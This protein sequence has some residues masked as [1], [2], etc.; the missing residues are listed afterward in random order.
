[1]T[2]W[3]LDKG[4]K[5]D[6]SANVHTND[7]LSNPEAMFIASQQTKFWVVWYISLLSVAYINSL[8]SLTLYVSLMSL[9]MEEGLHGIWMCH[10]MLSCVIEM[11][12]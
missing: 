7:Q 8:H 9:V 11:I 4:T 12:K 1:V 3:V 10:G 2:Q 5:N 6:L